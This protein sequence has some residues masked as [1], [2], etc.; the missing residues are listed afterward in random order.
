MVDGYLMNQYPG[1]MILFGWVQ[2]SWCAL[3]LID[4]IISHVEDDIDIDLDGNLV[5]LGS[6]PAVRTTVFARPTVDQG[7]TTYW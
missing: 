1:C 5:L 4:L 3:E 7:S 2:I 6:Q